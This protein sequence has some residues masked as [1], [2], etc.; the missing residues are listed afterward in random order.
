MHPGIRVPGGDVTTSTLDGPTLRSF[1]DSFAGQVVLPGD[2][3]YDAA[4]IVWNGMI[5]RRP[6]V[7]ARCT[8]V[9]DVLA[10]VRFAREQDLV[11][12]VRAGGHSVG[13]FS[14]CDDGI[15]ID[16]SAMRGVRVDPERRVARA[17]GGAHLRELDREAQAF[18]LACPVGVVG[19]TGVAGLT[20]GG[21]MGR[22]Q[23]K[24]GLTID[25]LLSVDLVT[26]DGRLVHASED[27][28]PDL[29]WGIR[30]AGPN[31]GVVTSFEFRLHP[32]GPSVLVGRRAFPMDRV[33]EVAA[34]H[35]EAFAT[36]PDEVFLSLGFGIVE[37]EEP[38]PELVGRPA[39]Y[40]GALHCGPFD[41]AERDLAP[42]LSGGLLDG[43]FKE[44]T[45]LSVQSEGDEEMAWG[46][47]FYMKGGY[48][49]AI[50]P[51]L[52]DV[53][54]GYVE[55]AGAGSIGFWAQEGAIARLPED[56]TAFAGRHA[57]FWVGA[58]TFWEDPREDE[59][60]IGWG[61]ESWA[62]L[63]PFTTAG[64][65]VNDLV[66][67]SDDLAR[68]SY[69]EAKYDRLV[70]LKRAYDPENVFRLNQNIKP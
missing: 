13:G 55:K 23:R 29:F 48:V 15:V 1:R 14:T 3:E 28:N 46:K 27:E 32:I 25:N 47:R 43:A 19:H 52:V 57:G 63:T 69:G 59:A 33:E 39:V 20:L 31:F 2:T 66:E 24:H 21:G 9:A 70:G 54:A 18:G 6:A 38:W 12:A 68:A 56:A 42:L 40:L 10:A 50:S 67:A 64:H 26:A 62:A 5:D 58:E 41:G 11:V 4:R 16:L 22:L 61:R 65:Y 34:R 7:V 30:G 49:N 37:P 8:G 45:Y 44:R 60:H 51:D 53:C 35:A 36:C 17:N